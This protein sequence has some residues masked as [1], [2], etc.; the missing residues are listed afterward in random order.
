MTTQEQ[1]SEEDKPLLVLLRML[2]WARTYWLAYLGIIFFVI[3]ASL[4]PVGWAE[5]MRQLFDATSQLN[6][7]GLFQASIWFGSLFVVEVAV[8]FLQALLNQRLSNRTTLDMQ[9]GLL[10]GLFAMKL[11]RYMKWHTG[12]KLQRINSSAPTAQEGINK[13]IPE[14]VHNG[15]SILFLFVYLTILSWELMAGAIVVALLLP[16]LS[17]MLAK[18]IRKWQDKTNEGHGKRD[19]MLLDQLQGA[20]VVRSYGLRSSFNKAWRD[21]VEMTRHRW[22]RTELLRAVNG[23]A[24]FI[25]FWLGQVYIFCMGASMAVNGSLAV[26]A[27]AAFMLSYERLVFPLAHLI[28]IWSSVSD[29]IAHAKRVYEMIDPSE[30]S[31]AKVSGTNSDAL[32][33]HGDIILDQISC[34][35]NDQDPIL[36]RLSLTIR[37][38]RVTAIVGPSG[39][40]KSTLI[41]LILGLHPPSS[42]T[43]RYGNHDLSEHNVE[44]W[45]RLTAYVPQDAAL[46][47]AT[48][49]DNIRIGRLDATDEE[50]AEAAIH[51]NAHSFIEALPEGYATRLGERGLRLSGGERQRLA[52]ARAYLR[53]PRFLLLD[54]PTS[55][56]DGINERLMQDALQSVMQGRTVLVAAHRLSTVEDADCIVYMEN[57]C[58]I[59]SGTHEQLLQQEGKYA[60]LVK[61]G[62]WSD[63]REESM[64]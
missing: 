40:G 41:K 38:G 63:L 55:A 8:S 5:A 52:L 20:E 12:D 37:Q 64:A 11:S 33:K 49:I 27:I 58:V 23:W 17:N 4:L 36:N 53:N 43:I 39:S 14:L 7:D 21:T 59:E 56:L 2:R 26:G 30:S 34:T 16:L 46:F 51:A 18:P 15:L 13:R 54:E 31:P 57:G 29:S 19:A 28:Q 6:M 62:D 25:G 50:V 24:V 9:R 1:A 48:V 44:A 3:I 10:G 32:P 42:G 61:A 60:A 45:R 22:L 47:D 35:Y